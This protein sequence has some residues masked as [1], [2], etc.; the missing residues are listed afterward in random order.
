MFAVEK[1]NENMNNSGDSEAVD[2]CVDST[3]AELHLT[4]DKRR[5]T[6]STHLNT[7]SLSLL[8]FIYGVHRKWRSFGV[9][10]TVP[11]TCIIIAKFG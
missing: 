6:V 3:D 1:E 8:H 4:D 2:A 5:P 9:G 7:T 11:V 10:V